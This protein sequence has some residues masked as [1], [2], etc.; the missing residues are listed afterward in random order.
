MITGLARILRD[1]L[2]WAAVLGQE[3]SRPQASMLLDLIHFRL[4]AKLG[5]PW[6][7]AYGIVRLGLRGYRDFVA[8][9]EGHRRLEEVAPVE[10]RFL[11]ESKLAFSVACDARGIPTV[12]LDA[13]VAFRDDLLHGWQGPVARTAQELERMLSDMG[14]MDAIVKTQGGGQGYGMFRIQVAG[15]KL[16]PGDGY[17]DVRQL[18]DRMA[19]KRVWAGGYV[20]Q[21]RLSS[22]PALRELSPGPGL[23]TIRLNTF[24]LASGSV[25]LPWAFFKIPGPDAVH[26]NWRMGRGGGLLCPVELD[27]GGLGP[28]IGR[29]GPRSPLR[30]FQRHPAGGAPIEGVQ[31]P[32]WEKVVALVRVGAERFPE[33]PALGWDVAILESGPVVLEA[34]WGWTI[35]APQILFQRGMKAEFYDLLA[36]L[37]KPRAFTQAE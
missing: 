1:Y 20:L 17:A 32:H 10:F 13:V 5:P 3:H 12:P 6:Y 26:D 18:F 27:T 11:E 16:Q 14:D 25:E 30:R 2:E 28:G 31:I 29:S 37:A 23:G 9:D 33:L 24:L 15:G 7:D 21:R 8:L 19:V 4:K 34:N 22:H 35:A 36:R